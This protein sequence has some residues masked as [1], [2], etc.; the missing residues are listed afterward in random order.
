MERRL[1]PRRWLDGD[2]TGD[3]ECAAVEQAG[4][5]ERVTAPTPVPNGRPEF[6]ALSAAPLPREAPR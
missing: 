4:R 5:R 2:R 3:G 6:L 1:H